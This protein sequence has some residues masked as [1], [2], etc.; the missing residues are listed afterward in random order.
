[1]STPRKKQLHVELDDKMHEDL[2]KLCPE[3]GMKTILVRRLLKKFIYY[4]NAVPGATIGDALNHSA[5]T[6]AKA[7]TAMEE[8]EIPDGSST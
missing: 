5:E 1:M 8:E 6:V 7:W 3:S 2:A 4:M